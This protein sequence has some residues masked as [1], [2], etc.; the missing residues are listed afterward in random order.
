MEKGWKKLNGEDSWEGFRGFCWRNVG[1]ILG[2]VYHCDM[3]RCKFIMIGGKGLKKIKRR[4]FV[5][6]I[7]LG[8]CWR[9]VGE[10][11][12]RVYHCDMYRCKFIMIRGKGLKKIERRRFVGEESW[13]F[14]GFVGKGSLCWK[15][16][17][18]LQF[19]RKWSIEK[20]VIKKSYGWI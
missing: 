19:W 7:S 9:N 18:F 3:Y 11:L 4:R 17:L 20:R 14:R 6:G 13:W 16:W 8:F 12:G 2:R 10:N 15:E 5:G 1:E